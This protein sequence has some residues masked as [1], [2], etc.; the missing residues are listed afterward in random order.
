MVLLRWTYSAALGGWE[1]YSVDSWPVH[2]RG[3]QWPSS[4]L[5]SIA[6][7]VQSERGSDESLTNIYN[8]CDSGHSIGEQSSLCS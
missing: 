3:L 1:H 6:E 8:G 7:A 5:W 4:V 2:S